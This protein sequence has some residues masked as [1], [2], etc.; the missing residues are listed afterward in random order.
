MINE[1]AKILQNLNDL[2]PSFS[3]CKQHM[4]NMLLI[5]AKLRLVKLDTISTHRLELN[6]FFAEA[7]ARFQ[8]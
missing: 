1:E 4:Q 5:Y 6:R 8:A 3:S 2:A 7:A